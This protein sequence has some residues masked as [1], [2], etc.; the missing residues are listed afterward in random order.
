MQ[1]CSVGVGCQWID[2]VDIIEV[3]VFIKVGIWIAVIEV[4]LNEGR[5]E[6][7]IRVEFDVPESLVDQINDND[8]GLTV[9]DYLQARIDWLVEQENWNQAIIV[10]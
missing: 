5:K 10:N 6:M 9:L 4:T 1:K 7:K 2:S 3:F 8:R